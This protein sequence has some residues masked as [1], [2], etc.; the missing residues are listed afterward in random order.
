MIDLSELV[1]KTTDADFLRELV[2]YGAQR[3]MALELEGLCGGRPPWRIGGERSEARTDQCHG[4]R[5]RRWETRA[6]T[7]DLQIPKLRPLTACWPSRLPASGWSGCCRIMA[8]TFP[9]FLEPRRLT[10][11][12]L[13]AVVQ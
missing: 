6:G 13:V 4:Y 3:L 2:G 9:S 8:A 10:D 11:R 1:D 7:V 12:V 5:Q